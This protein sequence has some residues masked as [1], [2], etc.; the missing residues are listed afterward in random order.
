MLAAFAPSRGFVPDG[1]L[2]FFC[3]GFEIS[4]AFL[5]AFALLALLLRSAFAIFYAWVLVR[6]LESEPTRRP[7][8]P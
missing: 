6:F 7:F 8:L 3:E 5:A 4:P 2:G 1:D